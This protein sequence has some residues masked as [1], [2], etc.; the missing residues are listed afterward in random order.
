MTNQP[1]TNSD[2]KSTIDYNFFL[3]KLQ[4]ANPKMYKILSEA[5]ELE[6][7]RKNLFSYS[8]QIERDMLYIQNKI[9]P[10]DKVI[11][12]DSIRTFKNIIGPVNELRTNISALDYLWKLVHG[13]FKSMKEEVSIGFFYEF[14]H[15][16]KSMTGHSGVYETNLPGLDNR[17]DF[18]Q[19]EGKEA[20]DNRTRILDSIGS[21][22]NKW[23]SRY[24][25]GLDR[26]V[27]QRRK[28]N[29]KRI[30]EYF[31]AQDND[32]DDY[33][34][35]LKH[36]IR[37][38]E[39]LID[40]IELTSA[41]QETVKK[42][43]KNR[44][45]FGITPYYLSLMDPDF[46]TRNDHAVRAQVIPPA[47]Y[48]KTMITHKFNREIELDFMGEHDTSPIDLVTRRYPMIAIL[49]PYNTCA[50]ICVYCQRNW[51][52]DEVLSPKAM[53]TK[54]HLEDAVKWFDDHP[55]IGDILITGG[56]PCIMKLEYFREILETVAAK[57]HVFRI[58]I[59]TRTPVVLPMRWTNEYTQMIASFH[60][61]PHREIAIITHIEHSYEITPETMNAV[62]KIKQA[63]ISVYNQEVFTFENSRR[64]ETAKLRR[65]LRSI[66]IDP[67][68]NFN[69]KG[70]TEMNQYRVP[71][72]RILQEQKEEARLLPGLDR[73]DESVFNV[74]KL[75]K[76]H[77]RASQDH[78]LIMIQPDGNRIYELH[79]W[80]KNISKVPRYIYTDT[81]IY[82]YL[83]K[84]KV[85]GE[86]I[87]DY[88]PSI[89]YYY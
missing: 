15:L 32:W 49:K 69:M 35:Q 56:D 87:E 62:Q 3:N 46:S 89:W 10:L 27:I 67:Y 74:P 55:D 7:A 8:E 13:N 9:D 71:I 20:I 2:D 80:E 76:N 88:T 58:R 47:D 51:E 6:T 73:T 11:T 79:A 53:S 25:S 26:S 64:F 33:I 45:P 59:G 50:Q 30:C 21:Y 31:N 29:K 48:I 4:N 68:Y 43:C 22:V 61:P 34:W 82:E 84:L 36:V 75:G 81:S 44:I 57:K 70:K 42:A 83:Q 39:P 86:N 37:D 52:I 72:A 19:L 14:L 40:L 5:D 78:R 28:E 16:F 77:L 17:T 65:D 1:I 12:Q 18:L 41:Q 54:K 38:P 85:I 66:G 60:Q 63:G 24:L 23:M